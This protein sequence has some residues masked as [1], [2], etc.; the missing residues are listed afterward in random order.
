MLAG[1]E[2]VEAAPA[3]IRLIKIGTTIATNTVIMLTGARTAL[4]TTAG[5]TDVLH[6]ARAARPTLYDSDRDRRP[7]WWTASLTMSIS[8]LQPWYTNA[9]KSIAKTPKVHFL[10]SGLLAAVREMSFDQ[11]K[12]DRGEFGALLESFV[13][14]EVLKLMTA[15]DLQLTAYHFR[16]QQ[17]HEVEI[18]LPG[19]IFPDRRGRCRLDTPQPLSRWRCCPG[20]R[21]SE[22][23]GPPQIS[24]RYR[25]RTCG[26]SDKRSGCR[27]RREAVSSAWR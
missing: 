13:F 16:D 12:S 21:V 5:F 25:Y 26:D 2:A 23:V 3:A 9:L 22:K 15:S 11:V 20:T 24:S 18:V 14:S 8:T 19:S 4:V 27:T 1:I 17:M 6:A 7:R 10:D